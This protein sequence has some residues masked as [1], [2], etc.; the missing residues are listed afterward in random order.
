M[1]LLAKASK[2]EQKKECNH[3]KRGRLSHHPLIA[4]VNDVRLIANMWLCSGYSSLLKGY[5]DD[6]SNYRRLC[7]LLANNLSLCCQL[8]HLQCVRD[9]L[10]LSTHLS[11]VEA[12]RAGCLSS[13]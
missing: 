12:I 2:R 4:F 6:S 11:M 10:L 3:Y 5:V 9:G 7:M 13:L 8:L 1:L